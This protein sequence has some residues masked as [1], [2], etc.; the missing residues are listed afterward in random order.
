[1]NVFTLYTRARGRNL[2]HTEYVGT[3]QTICVNDYP[4]IAPNTSK[5]IYP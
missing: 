5:N 2:I 1:M 3:F 4:Y